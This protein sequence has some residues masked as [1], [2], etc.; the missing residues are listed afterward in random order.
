MIVRGNKD[1]IV[2]IARSANVVGT[3][4]DYDP[5]T[6]AYACDWLDQPTASQL[7]R[8]RLSEVADSVG[9]VLGSLG[10]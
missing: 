4:V 10:N 2:R 9:P 5:A 6:Q 7:N 3:L 8:S 1:E